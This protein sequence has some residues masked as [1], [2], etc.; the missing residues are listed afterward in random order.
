MVNYYIFLLILILLLIVFTGFDGF[1]RD[2]MAQFAV[3]VLNSIGTNDDMASIILP[4]SEN[5]VVR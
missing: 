4:E 2:R 5:K 3:A 1:S